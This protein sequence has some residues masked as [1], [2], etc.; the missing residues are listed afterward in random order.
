[1]HKEDVGDREDD[2]SDKCM[3]EKSHEEVG[4]DHAGYDKVAYFFEHEEEEKD[5]NEIVEEVAVHAV[6]DDPENGAWV[7]GVKVLRVSMKMKPLSLIH[8]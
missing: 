2:A 1:M 3:G 5:S 7:I 4:H 6:R 8:I